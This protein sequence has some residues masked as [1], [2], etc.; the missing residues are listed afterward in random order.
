M[1]NL[2]PCV[3]FHHGNLVDTGD[4]LSFTS[5]M[6]PDDS[7]LR[8]IAAWT[9]DRPEKPRPTELT[10]IALNMQTASVTSRMVMSQGDEF[11]RFD[12]R[13]VGRPARYLYTMQNGEGYALQSLHRLDV[14]SGTSQH[15]QAGAGYA[16][17]E[18]IFVPR[19]DGTRE[20]HGWLLH[21]GYS[22]ERD[23]TFLDVRD[24]ATLERAARIWTGQHFPLGL[25]GNFYDELR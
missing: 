17:E 24:A 6:S 4:E 8:F 2:P 3:V 21:Q 23:E 16:F 20:D 25:H 12:P 5:L 10:R 13:L 15:I 14:E 18:T 1:F 7:I 22:A 11:P 19:G 9:S